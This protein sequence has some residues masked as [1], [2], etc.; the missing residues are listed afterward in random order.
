M[1]RVEIKY[2][3][4]VVAFAAILFLVVLPYFDAGAS[5]PLPADTILEAVGRLYPAQSDPDNPLPGSTFEII[6]ISDDQPAI[7]FPAITDGSQNFASIADTTVIQGYP[8]F[9][10]G[11]T[12]DMIAGFDPPPPLSEDMQQL[13]ALVRF[14]ISGL[15]SGVNVT[16]ATLQLRLVT[17]ADYPGNSKTINT[18][19]VS[20]DWT[21]STNWGNKPTYAEAYGS[22]SIVFDQTSRW[23]EFDVTGLIDKWYTGSEMNYGILLHSPDASSGNPGWRGFGTRESSYPPV[24]VV[25]FDT[26]ATATATPTATPFQGVDIP[27]YLPYIC[28]AEIIEPTATNTPIPPEVSPTPT[29]TPTPTPTTAPSALSKLYVNGKELKPSPPTAGFTQYYLGRPGGGT[30]STQTFTTTLTGDID[31]DQFEFS[32]LFASLSTTTFKATILVEG[33]AV[34]S[35]DFASSSTTYTRFT[36]TVTGIDP[37]TSNGDEI[38]LY[39]QW[40]SGANGAMASGPGSAAS[41]IAIPE[42]H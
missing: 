33:Q 28:K 1:N 11:G 17:A 41:Y 10:A 3:L 13:M 16:K 20:S 35:K 2:V 31:G 34:A 23:V 21:E 7:G 38:K 18:Y 40:T 19:R 26:E 29:N 6:K 15:P 24:L 27:A 42:Q 25:E 9:N 14:D 32:I 4:P 39:V 8:T 30:V 37:S 36:S 22:Q 5:P 12:S